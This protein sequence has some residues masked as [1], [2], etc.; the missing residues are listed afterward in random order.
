MR[1]VLDTNVFVSGVLGGALAEV[2]TRWQAGEF[3]VVVSDAI[4]REYLEVLRRPKFGL[5]AEVIDH[6]GAY[7]FQNADFV[8]PTEVLHVVPN[9]PKDDKFIEAAV[10]GEVD[11]VVSGDRHL[12]A[13]G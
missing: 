7:L 2:I 12:L 10:A 9:D 4:A 3:T 11:L 5:P 1:V 8:T 6:I 13:L